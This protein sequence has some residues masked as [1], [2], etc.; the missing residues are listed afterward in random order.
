MQGATLQA[1]G[2]GGVL[3]LLAVQ[4]NSP[5]QCVSVLTDAAE[6]LWRRLRCGLFGFLQFNKALG[7]FDSSFQ[8]GNRAG[9]WPLKK[10]MH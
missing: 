10:H 1:W 8:R 7:F 6:N 9:S 2:V 5:P 3:C 4:N